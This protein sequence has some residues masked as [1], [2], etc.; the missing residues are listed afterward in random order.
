MFSS[1][2]IFIDEN[3]KDVSYSS[4]KKSENIVKCL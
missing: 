1:I 2:F 3:F 4:L